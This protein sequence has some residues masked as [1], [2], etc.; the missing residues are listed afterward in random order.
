M[1]SDVLKICWRSSLYAQLT[2]HVQKQGGGVV[3]GT[4]RTQNRDTFALGAG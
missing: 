4:L 3:Q 2:R 1:L